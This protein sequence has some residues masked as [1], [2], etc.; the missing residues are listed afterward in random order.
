MKDEDSKAAF[1]PLPIL[2]DMVSDM[3]LCNLSKTVAAD[4]LKE[5]GEIKDL[6]SAQSVEALIQMLTGDPDNK[7]TFEFSDVV[8][9]RSFSTEPFEGYQEENNLQNAKKGS[10]WLSGFETLLG[11]GVINVKKH[12]ASVK[13]IT[14][15]VST[16]GRELS[17]IIQSNI[18]I[19]I[20][21]PVP[22]GDKPNAEPDTFE[23]DPNQSPE[24]DPTLIKTP[25]PEKAEVEAPVDLKPVEKIEE[26]K[27][28]EPLRQEPLRLEEEKSENI[29]FDQAEEVQEKTPL[30]QKS[31]EKEK[32]SRLM[33]QLSLSKIQEI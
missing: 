1:D 17:G 23:F 33:K 15:R 8:A 3:Q 16:L 26:K 7:E 22:K 2:E 13:N 19:E 11:G 25:S 24:I 29:P 9:Q 18:N 12:K 4:M 27:Q 10:Q 21:Q 32:P 28:E 30:A 20:T 5:M 6:A 31:V 14:S